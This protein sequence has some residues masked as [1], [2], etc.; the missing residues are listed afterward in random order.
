[1]AE[2][3]AVSA[4]PRLLVVEPYYGGSHKAFLDGLI[5]QVQADCL[6]LSLPARKW[7][8]RMQLSAPWFVQCIKDLPG[9]KRFFDT[10]LCSTF[11]DVAVF[12]SLVSQLRG[13]NPHT[14]FCT[15]FHENQFVY[16]N[17]IA[18]PSIFQFSAINFSTAL[19][20]DSLAFNSNFNFSSFLTGNKAYLKKA[21]DMKLLDSQRDI[22]SRSEVIHPGID[23]DSI[24]RMKGTGQDKL[25]EGRAPVIIWNHRWEHDKNPAEFFEV[26]GEIKERGIGF[27]LIVLG[28]S[29]ENIPDCF[30]WAQERFRD[31]I[32]HFGYAES[33]DDYSSWLKK[34]DIVIST[35]IHE[36]FGIS[37]LEAVR[38]GCTPI[39]PGRLS[40]PELFPEKYLYKDGELADKL[41]ALIEK[42]EFIES[43]E[44]D[45][46]T[47]NYSWPHL[48]KKYESW[49]F[50]NRTDT[51]EKV[52]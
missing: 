39:L 9:D 20:S 29:Y 30:G 48:V 31:E 43:S 22:A 11:V 36:F 14:R 5:S 34:G 4:R 12:R 37:V 6:L 38:A 26:L 23:F 16:P 32:I 25:S 27:K 21:S 28:E 24:D 42:R 51:C 17:Q 50:T 47:E 18:D 46:L 10:V 15:Y 41:C 13:W 2:D 7:K 33:K 40:Y 8:M 35:A 49:L 44:A 3:F 45:K 19:C 52:T 1:M